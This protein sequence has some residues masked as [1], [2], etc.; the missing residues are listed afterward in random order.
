[1]GTFN[2]NILPTATGLDLGSNSQRWDAY[3][4]NLDISGSLI[5]GIT[6]VID[7]T[8]YGIVGDGSTNNVADWAVMMA[9]VVTQ[10]IRE[11]RFPAGKFMFNSK[12]AAIPNGVIL[13]AP[14]SAGTTF[15]YGATL[16]ANY[17]ESTPTNGFL[18]WDGANS[19]FGGGG[20][21]DGFDIQKATT[22]TGGVAIKLIGTTTTARPSFMR[23]AN[24][25]VSGDN[26]GGGGTWNY[27]VYVDGSAITTASNQGIRDVHF[28]NCYFFNATQ[29]SQSIYLNNAVHFYFNGCGVI[30]GNGS[31]TGVTITGASA[32]ATTQS[33]NVY[34][35]GVEV[36]GTIIYDFCQI[37][38]AAGSS[39]SGQFSSTANCTTSV[40][41]G[42]AG[43][44]SNLG[45]CFLFTNNGIVLPS[46]GTISTGGTIQAV[47]GAV[48]AGAAPSN[49]TAGDVCASS[50]TTGG[51]LKLG[52]DGQTYVRK[53]ASG[54]QYSFDA[55]ATTPYT[56][57]SAG[58]ETLN[59]GLVINNVAAP[60]VA[61]NQ[62]GLGSTTASTVGAAG[63]ASA[64]PAT[65]SGY[66]IINVAGTAFKL[67]YYAT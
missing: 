47:T 43:S 9:D 60:T 42:L 57:D 63:G 31:N 15:T 8:T 7:P 3:V 29:S 58:K 12:P 24:L 25:R 11:I 59:G 41:H 51:T 13:T 6:S 2:A 1:M 21:L 54:I 34:L 17:T 39:C 35:N 40:Y 28:S 36:T 4:R 38:A 50:S 46:T 66:L 10:N 26:S 53:N 23:F 33:Q 55:G 62:I 27:N 20:G 30:T 18:T 49:A 19:T 64:L 48:V 65:P 67:P 56:F 32:T 14:Y 45:G 22:F 37:V 52:S 5:G 16:V 61:A 44:I